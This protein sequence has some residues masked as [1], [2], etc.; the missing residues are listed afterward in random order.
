MC[1]VAGLRKVWTFGDQDAVKEEAVV[2]RWGDDKSAKENADTEHA[3]L[4][5]KEDGTPQILNKRVL[6]PYSH[7]CSVV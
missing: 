1:N 6:G 4:N 7:G 5:P 2:W 3:E